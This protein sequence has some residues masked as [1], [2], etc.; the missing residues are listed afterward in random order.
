MRKLIAFFVVV[1]VA[2]TA[3]QASA[4]CATCA[5]SAPSFSQPAYSAPQVYSAPVEQVYSAP[6]AP[7]EQAYAAPM[8]YE[9]A[10]MAYTSSAPV[11]T[12]GCS[13]CSSCSS[14]G[15]DS[16]AAGGQMSP[17]STQGL[18]AGAV[19]ISDVVSGSN[20]S[21]EGASVEGTVVGDSGSSEA[22]SP[23]EAAE[24]PAPQPQE[25]A[26]VPPLP[27][28]EGDAGEDSEASDGT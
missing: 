8:A 12:S 1:A 21:E 26:V 11:E 3:N 16:V 22:G 19:I 27:T 24:P 14:C 17:Y 20:A 28:E 10:P 9:S 6:M 23:T 15:G 5:G 7:V 18:P 25:D 4:Q 13:S 2:V